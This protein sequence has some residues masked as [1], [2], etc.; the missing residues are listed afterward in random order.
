RAGFA[1]VGLGRRTAEDVVS[2]VRH[3][4]PARARLTV[5]SGAHMFSAMGLWQADEPNDVLK[6]NGLSTMG[7]A[8]PAAIAA[9]LE[10]PARPVIAMTGDGGL[11]MCLAELATTA[12]LGCRI[13]VVVFNDSALS[14]IDIKQQRQ[15]RESRGVRFGDMD[16]AQVAEGLGCR[17]WRVGATDALTPAL[18]EAFART[19]PVLIDVT[20]DPE[21]YTAQYE[22]LRG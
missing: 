16:H 10:E 21:A 19:G 7:F 8:L 15:Q 20:I 4:A 9:A 5:D 1:M 2:A 11:H 6:S 13:A 12:R 18:M 14:L 17:G 3:A 22:A